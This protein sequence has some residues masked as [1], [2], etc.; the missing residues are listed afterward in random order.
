MESMV[1]GSIK[2][3]MMK[4]SLSLF[5]VLT[6]ASLTTNKL[7]MVD[8]IKVQNSHCKSE[9]SSVGFIEFNFLKADPVI[10]TEPIHPFSK[11]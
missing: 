4:D 1:N 7:L 11:I 3:I 10:N 8:L 5:D 6:K 2:S 9:F